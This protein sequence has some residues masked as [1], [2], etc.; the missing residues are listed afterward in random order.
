MPHSMHGIAISVIHERDHSSV[1]GPLPGHYFSSMG[2][3]PGSP[4]PSSN[5]IPHGHSHQFHHSH[6]VLP[7]QVFFKINKYM[8]IKLE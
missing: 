7:M 8:Y 4:H 6:P 5:I 3:N 1:P 2:M